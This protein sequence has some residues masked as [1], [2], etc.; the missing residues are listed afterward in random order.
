MEFVLLVVM[1][2]NLLWNVFD[3]ALISHCHHSCSFVNAF[4][5]ASLS[6]LSDGNFY[7]TGYIEMAVNQRKKKILMNIKFIYCTHEAVMRQLE[8]NKGGIYLCLK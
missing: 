2:S 1:M 4:D 3:G 6:V 5:N 8:T 7:R